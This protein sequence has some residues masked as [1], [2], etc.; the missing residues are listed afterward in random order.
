LV[1]YENGGALG[2][3]LASNSDLKILEGWGETSS[4]GVTGADREANVSVI[5]SAVPEPST[6]AMMILGFCGEGFMAYRKQNAATLRLISCAAAKWKGRLR[7][8]FLF[9]KLTPRAA[10][11]L[12]AELITDVAILNAGTRAVAP[13]NTIGALVPA[14][15][16]IGLCNDDFAVYEVQRN[17]VF[18]CKS[19]TAR[20]QHYA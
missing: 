14:H 11:S 5:Y 9:Q 7:A 3:T 15:L 18:L 19:T 4:F 16:A 20:Q 17:R 12:C 2:S 8:V 13:D 10:S 6:W 1:A